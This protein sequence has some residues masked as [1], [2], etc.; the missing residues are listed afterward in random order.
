[1]HVSHV[2][3]RGLVNLQAVDVNLVNYNTL[4]GKNDSGKTSFLLALQKLLNPAHPLQPDYL[5]RILGH[6]NECSMEFKFSE[7]THRLAQNGE[8]SA[9]CRKSMVANINFDR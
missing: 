8:L 2:K 6:A 9:R 4:I 3:T 1:M 5:C 7:S